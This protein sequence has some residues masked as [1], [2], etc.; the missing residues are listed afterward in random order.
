M[1]LKKLRWAIPF[2]MFALALLTIFRFYGMRVELETNGLRADLN[3]SQG[4]VLFLLVGFMIGT[5]NATLDFF[6]EKYTTKKLPLGL[7]V[8]FSSLCYLT[9]IIL[10]FSVSVVLLNAFY[11]LQMEMDYNW[12]LYDKNF[13]AIAFYMAFASLVFSFVKIAN[14]KFGKGVLLK[15]L[16][17][18]YKEPKEED[19]IFMFLDLRSST[20]I[21]EELGHLKY[22]QLIQDCFYDMNEVVPEYD[23]EIY[24]YVGDEAVISWPYKHGLA[25]NN[26]I[27]LYFAFNERLTMKENY[28]LNRYG[29]TP[30]FKAGIHG[31]KLMVAEVGIVKK[32]IAYHGDVINTSARIQSECNRH[33]VSLLIS[34]YLFEQLSIGQLYTSRLVGDVLLRGKKKEMR[35]FTLQKAYLV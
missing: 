24:Q 15:M 11:H 2:W 34:E 27:E 21:A 35:V 12:W 33:G 19:R 8:L 28:Y 25:K 1:Y 22:S 7:S 32:E 31:G 9:S 17:G 30:K 26:C 20:T 13:R 18:K 23:A 16:L 3:F 4:L 5:V 29:I 14:D 10:I 6:F